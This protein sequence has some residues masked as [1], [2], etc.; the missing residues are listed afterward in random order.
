MHDVPEQVDQLTVSIKLTDDT[1]N[2][3]FWLAHAARRC[4]ASLPRV[5]LLA[6]DSIL[7]PRR[8]AHTGPS[9]VPKQ[10]M[11]QTGQSQTKPCGGATMSDSDGC[12]LNRPPLS[13]T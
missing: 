8:L 11:S 3:I 2:D 4:L 7:A 1:V 13:S 12:S 9:N 6:H 10:G 5:R